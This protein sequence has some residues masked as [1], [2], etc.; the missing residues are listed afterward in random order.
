M[1]TAFSLLKLAKA[2]SMF[3]CAK[4][5][6]ATTSRTAAAASLRGNVMF[7][8]IFFIVLFICWNHV[9]EFVGIIILNA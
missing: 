4:E 8:F 1:V 9:S 2:A 7:V 6:E 5:P 3:F